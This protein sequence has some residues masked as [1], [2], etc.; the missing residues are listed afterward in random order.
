[1]VVDSPGGEWAMKLGPIQ[2]TNHAAT[3]EQAE[4]GALRQLEEAVN[5]I[6]EKGRDLVPLLQK[7]AVCVG[8]CEPSVAEDL[9]EPKAVSYQ[10]NDGK[11]FTV[12]VSGFFGFKLACKG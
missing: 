7:G 1:M 2:R 8:A 3:R 11:W 12:A 6:M 10:L 4:E 5:E 9:A